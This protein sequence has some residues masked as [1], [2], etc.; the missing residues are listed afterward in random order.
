MQ[1]I[2]RLEPY[3]EGQLIR[4]NKYTPLVQKLHIFIDADRNW[5]NWAMLLEN[6]P[7]RPLLPNLRV[8]IVGAQGSREDGSRVERCVKALLCPTLSD[9]RTMWGSVRYMDP[10][11]AVGLLLGIART[12]PN[13]SKLRL[14]VRHSEYPSDLGSLG[15]YFKAALVITI[16]RFQN[17]RVLSTSSTVLDPDILRL[18]GNL[19]HLE[20]LA[21]ASP[22]GAGRDD[23]Q[24]WVDD[25][26]LP[27]QLFPALR[28]LKIYSVPSTIV[29]KLW[30]A[31]P[32]V[33]NLV[34]ITVIFMRGST[35]SLNGLICDICR[36]S[37]FTVDLDLDLS[38]A[39]NVE[40]SSS[41]VDHLRQL[42]LQ[43]VRI[44]NAQTKFQNLAPAF[45]NVEYL[46]MEELILS[47]EDLL[48]MSKSMPKL[49]Y[50]AASLILWEWPS[51][52]ELS[53]HSHHLER[54]I[55]IAIL[56]LNLS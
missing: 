36:G 11:Q 8:L 6:V 33:Q 44:S 50:L 10:V 2:Q 20:S 18:L 40:I 52:S 21:A 46:K 48:L 13:L 55:L 30:K 32:L 12:C 41:V 16:G 15:T 31:A 39:R 28:H 56:S 54:A 17:L 45:R 34:S 38:D 25:Y 53:H 26:A 24:T 14:L 51:V 47:Y 22:P 23:V 37:P 27:T 1:C 4:F 19:P 3:D 9:I 49:Q 42:P 43:R 29:S 5:P 35:E 7:I